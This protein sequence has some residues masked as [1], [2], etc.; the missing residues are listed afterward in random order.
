MTDAAPVPRVPTAPETVP[1]L[2]AVTN[3]KQ[4]FD[5]LAVKASTVLSY[6][7]MVGLLALGGAAYRERPVSQVAVAAVPA[8]TPAYAVA[9]ASAADVR[10]RPVTTV[11]ISA[12]PMRET[13]AE[14]VPSIKS[15]SI[16]SP[17]P[18]AEPNAAPKMAANTASHSVPN[19]VMVPP[20]KRVTPV[21]PPLTPSLA[22][23]AE[24]PAPKAVVNAPEKA[25][26]KPTEA[27]AD[28]LPEAEAV[29][30][31]TAPAGWP[32]A[33][34]A[35]ALR[36]CTTVL[37][38]RN[39]QF[40]HANPVRQGSCGTPAPIKLKAIGMPEV[41]LANPA[42]MNC[43]VAVAVGNWVERVLQP[44][45]T[46][47][48]ASPVVRLVGTGSYTCR[49]RNGASDGPISEHAFANAF[50]VAGFV[51]A[52]GRTVNVLGGWGRVARDDA[53]GAKNTKVVAAAK[54]VLAPDSR[55]ALKGPPVV[56]ATGGEVAK[57]EVLSAE[58]KFLR[59]IHA[60]AC[61]LFGTVLGPEA[62]DA[63]RNHLHFDLKERKGKSY[64]Q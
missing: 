8:S 45:A 7:V 53:T 52:D 30:E 39:V 46:E 48:L 55:S 60:E 49:N 12:A 11:R 28:K 63:H 17:E 1:E 59:R 27:A 37:A 19:T 25:E 35:T 14:A 31:G 34:V 18:I 32:E 47:I 38:D 64:C 56:L 61:G 57:S 33:D 20:I 6:S 2:T 5:R 43:A 51:L 36:Q 10:S 22:K 40:E 42:I 44:A 24:A 13:A 41:S 58:A 9:A 4:R 23:M 54:P 29:A 15:P 26:E 62:N 16:K 50:D 3:V 21:T